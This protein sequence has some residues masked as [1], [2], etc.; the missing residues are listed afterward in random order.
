PNTILRY[1]H[2]PGFPLNPHNGLSM[3]W[4]AFIPD[5]AERWGKLQIPEGDSVC[6]A[7]VVD[8]L[9]SYGKRDSSFV[10]Y[11]FQRDLNENFCNRPCNMVDA[12]G[13]GCLDFII[14][15]TLPRSKKFK[16]DEPTLHILAH[17]TE[18]KGAEGNA[19]TDFVSFTQFGCLII[20][21][22]TSVQRV[23]G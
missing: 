6:C 4:L 14:A 19:A 3:A 8:P 11:K 1:P 21:D 15:L 12:F 13:Y 22:V 5:R 20:L 23:V 16:I 10:Q 17:I 18:A 7:A 9:L 2:L